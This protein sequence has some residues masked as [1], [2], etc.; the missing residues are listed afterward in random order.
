MESD[1]SKD[2]RK[3]LREVIK[4]ELVTIDEWPDEQTF[5]AMY[6]LGGNQRAQKYKFDV[7]SKIHRQKSCR[8]IY[9]LSLE[10]LAAYNAELARNLTADEWSYLKMEKLG[11]PSSDVKAISMEKG[12]L[13]T[14]TEAE[15]IA[16][17]VMQSNYKSLLVV[18][19][20]YHSQRVRLAFEHFL[21]GR[22][23]DVI[24]LGSGEPVY[25]RSLVLEWLK[26]KLYKVLLLMG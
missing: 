3:S 22:E 2:F 20:P 17:L 4:Q 12:M 14:M 18:A 5:D 8:N 25:L 9:F 16:K 21:S 15:N 26:L 6:L 13:G 1:M 24:I 7:A 11:I 10:G 23:I 19:A